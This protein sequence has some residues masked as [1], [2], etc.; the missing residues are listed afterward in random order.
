MLNPFAST[1]GLPVA[2]FQ[3]RVVSASLQIIPIGPPTALQGTLTLKLGY[4]WNS[5]ATAEDL[6]AIRDLPSGTTENANH[7][8]IGVYEPHQP[9]DIDFYQISED[10]DTGNLALSHPR[11]FCLIEGAAS[12]AKFTVVTHINYEFVPTKGLDYFSLAQ[13]PVS[14]GNRLNYKNVSDKEILADVVGSNGL[15]KLKSAQLI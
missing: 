13:T 7:P 15:G 5:F 3:Y 2:T 11:F 10:F 8:M 12:G 4:Y 9:A 14:N 6:D 1:S